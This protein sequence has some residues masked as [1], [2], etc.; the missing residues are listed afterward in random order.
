MIRLVSSLGY[1]TQMNKKTLKLKLKDERLHSEYMSNL[2]AK[3]CRENI[4]LHNEIEYLTNLVVASH[5][6]TLYKL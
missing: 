1:D 6:L 2:Y 4:R 3:K 5:D